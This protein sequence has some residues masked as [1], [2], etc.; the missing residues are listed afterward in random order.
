MAEAPREIQDLAGHDRAQAEYVW[1][2]RLD[3]KPSQPLNDDPLL[4]WMRVQWEQ[5]LEL[6]VPMDGGQPVKVDGFALMRDL[7]TTH[8]IFRDDVRWTRTGA[9]RRR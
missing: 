8:P 9:P 1:R 3:E 2:F 4:E 6:C 5:L 7:D